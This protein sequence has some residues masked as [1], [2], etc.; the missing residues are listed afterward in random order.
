MRRG[1]VVG[2]NADSAYALA[3]DAFSA[4][5]VAS[6]QALK[7]NGG[8][9][10]AVL[11]GRTVTLEGIVENVTDEM[12]SLVEAFWPGPLTILARPNRTLAW[13]ANSQAVSVRMP[14]NEWT[15]EIAS[16]LGPM[17][18]IAGSRGSHKA[19][20][21]ATQA[22]EIWGSDVPDWL[23][24]GMANPEQVSTVVDFRG[25]KPNIVRLGALTA[26]NLRQVVPSITMIAS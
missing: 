14:T 19:P 16:E 25:T 23:S 2:L 12:R 15:R 18:A 21:S 1:D 3:T 24:S 9:A 6:V 17:I 5:G 11:V 7:G 10:T 8:F 20:T 4:R 26:S 13:A 22:A